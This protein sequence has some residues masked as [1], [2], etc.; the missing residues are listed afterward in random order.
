[1]PL[2]NPTK[3]LVTSFDVVGDIGIATGPWTSLRVE[4]QTDFSSVTNI[5]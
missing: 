3:T 1:M 2:F 5:I 4:I